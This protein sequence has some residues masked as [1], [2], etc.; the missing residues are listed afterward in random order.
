MKYL[1]IATFIL[2]CQLP[3]SAKPVVTDAAGAFLNYFNSSKTMPQQKRISLFKTE[4]VPKAPALYARLFDYSSKVQKISEDS[5]ISMHL[6]EFPQLQSRYKVVYA[7]LKKD[8]D[9]YLKK[10]QE[11]FPDFKIDEVPIFIVHSLGGAN[12]A[13][14]IIDGKPIFYLGV[15]MIAKHNKWSDQQPFFD[16]EFFHVYHLQRFKIEPKLYSQLWMEGLA[17]YVS[18]KMNPRASDAEAM[19]D[20][21]MISKTKSA[22]PAIIKDIKANLTRPDPDNK[23]RFKYF[24]IDSKDQLI[25]TRSGYYV[26][27]LIAQELAKNATVPEMVS[28]QGDQLID[29]MRSAL[30]KISKD[31]SK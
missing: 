27:Y 28:W 11:E 19:L 31:A 25:P 2:L 6:K 18:R 17:T 9:S 4:I 13:A 22:L 15:D 7:Q 20:A 21:S 1:W 16:H 12:G 10:F 5:R 24:N 23:I 29:K 8:F 14:D 3:C 30:D 26:G